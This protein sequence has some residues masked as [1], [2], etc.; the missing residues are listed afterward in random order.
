MKT[1]IEHL[2]QYAIYH[3]DERNI[4]THFIGVP[5]I[6]LS[7]ICLLYIPLYNYMNIILTP[8]LLIIFSVSIFYI[9][10]EIKL[11]LIM[12]CCLSVGYIMA[13]L[14]FE[15]F[16]GAE[17]WF[18]AI[19]SIMF[20]IGWVVQFIGHYYEGKKPAF[21]DDLMG[22][23]IGPLFVAAEIAFKLGFFNKL[24]QQII[25]IAGPYKNRTFYRKWRDK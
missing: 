7:V 19:A 2:G 22:L 9:R 24:E 8:A 18:Y 11:G 6:V 5:L 4:L 14:S 21:V 15:Y 25:A 23:V 17:P 1:L 20:F 3:R 12:V 16:L 10:L 13:K